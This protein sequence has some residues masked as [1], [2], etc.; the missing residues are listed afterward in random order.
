MTEH[1]FVFKAGKVGGE[2]EK[3]ERQTGRSGR[4]QRM[5]RTQREGEKRNINISF[6]SLDWIPDTPLSPIY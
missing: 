1:G 5:S 4:G 2:G 3:I 6:H